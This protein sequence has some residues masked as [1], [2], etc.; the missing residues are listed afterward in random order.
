MTKEVVL[1]A[2]CGTPVVFDNV[3]DGYYAVCLHHDEDLYEFETTT[4]EN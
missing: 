4:E 3:T 1:C 2:R